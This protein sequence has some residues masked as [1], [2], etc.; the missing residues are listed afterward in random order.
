ML[1][2]NG[3]EKRK[4]KTIEKLNDRI[5]RYDTADEEKNRLI[6]RLYE[7]GEYLT[8]AHAYLNQK[9][10]LLAFLKEVLISSFWLCLLVVMPGILLSLL[11]LPITLSSVIATSSVGLVGSV[12]LSFLHELSTP[13]NGLTNIIKA[14]KKF[15]GV[16]LEP[17]KLK[18]YEE[19]YKRVDAKET[20][21]F[22]EEMKL[23]KEIGELNCILEK[24][25][26]TLFSVGSEK[27][28]PPEY[29]ETREPASL[30]RERKRCEMLL[31]NNSVYL[32]D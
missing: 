18:E 21:L 29:F 11:T 32:D 17:E 14:R 10:V 25:N 26:K 24:I 9:S 12:I 5:R 27:S 15:K 1:F 3:L 31:S 23:K 28:V 13:G 16:T 6:N 20:E 22:N 30:I 2:I 8:L 4:E 7:L 19:E